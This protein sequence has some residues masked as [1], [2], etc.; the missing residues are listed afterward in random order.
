LS[1]RKRILALAAVGAA[2]VM[3]GGA[4]S[5]HRAPKVEAAAATQAAIGCT[6]LNVLADV[7]FPTLASGTIISS[8]QGTGVLTPGTLSIITPNVVVWCG[9]VFEDAIPAA[10][11]AGQDLDPSTIDGGSIIFNLT[12]TN[13]VGMLTESSSNSFSVGCGATNIFEGCQGGN[14][15]SGPPAEAGTP[16]CWIGATPNCVAISP[17]AAN[18]VHVSLRPGASFSLIGGASPA[19]TLSATYSRFQSVTTLA[20]AIPAPAF[21][22]PVS[23]NAISIAV[24]TPVYAMTLTPVPA[25]IPAAS[26]TGVSST[27]TAAMYHVSNLC[28]TLGNLGLVN[29]TGGFF[30][31]GAGGVPNVVIGVVAGAESGV[32]TFSTNSGVFGSTAAALGG[33][34]Q[35]YSVHCGSLPGQSAVILIPTFGL[36]ANFPLTQCV[37]A[38]A[39][40]FG[41]GAAGTA[42]IVANFVGD[43]TG[44]TTNWTTTVGL[45][46]TAAT[47]N[48]NQGCNE[49]IVPASYAAGTPTAT[50]VG[51]AKGV[52]VV[53]AWVFNNSTHTFAA[54][55]FSVAGAPTDGFA[56][57]IA[58]GASIFLCVSGSGTFPTGAF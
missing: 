36:N 7:F 26:G 32:I 57:T 33:A 51:L 42:T 4:F 56:T 29:V 53:S 19:F 13:G 18:S 17:T 28:S 55:F 27:I 8:V 16:G 48:L 1:I 44:G 54:G 11:V 25:T 50:I 9:A 39:N 10:A 49:V 22:A 52:T 21:T 34:Q 35:V 6:N 31:C 37:S 47:V 14:F 2:A 30:I 20:G 43:Y 45:S 46:P 15:T 58:G 3:L 40:L 41:G 5:A 12:S 23:T 24:A 38:T